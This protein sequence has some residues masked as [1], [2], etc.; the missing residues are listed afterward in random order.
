MKLKKITLEQFEK[1]F[2]IKPYRINEFCCYGTWNGID[3]FTIEKNEDNAK[4]AMWERLKKAN[5]I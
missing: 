2:P 3:I 1:L 4:I 5:W